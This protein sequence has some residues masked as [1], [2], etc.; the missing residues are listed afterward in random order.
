[1]GKKSISGQRRDSEKRKKESF[2]VV[3]SDLWD[4]NTFQYTCQKSPPGESTTGEK[5]FIDLCRTL[6]DGGSL[7]PFHHLPTKLL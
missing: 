6:E 7:E 5:H 3:Q 2:I 1:M 4:T